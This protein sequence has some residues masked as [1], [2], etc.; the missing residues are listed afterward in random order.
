MWSIVDSR[1]GVEE[2]RKLIW[3][4]QLLSLLGG[5]TTTIIHTTMHYS[6]Y[7]TVTA[8]KL[9]QYFFFLKVYSHKKN[10]FVF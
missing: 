7:T 4:I 5:I 6:K 1:G 9:N 2:E 8:S 3:K 10:V